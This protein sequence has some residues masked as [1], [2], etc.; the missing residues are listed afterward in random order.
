MNAEL[1]RLPHGLNCHNADIDHMSVLII[2]PLNYIDHQMSAAIKE[3][4]CSLRLCDSATTAF[5]LADK[6][7]PDL[8]V[9]DA[10]LPDMELSLFIRRFKRLYPDCLLLSM[11]NAS[12]SCDAAEAMKAGAIDYLRKPFNAAQ[13]CNCLGHA[14][15]ANRPFE[16]LIVASH[17][18]RQVLQLARRAAQTQASILITGESGTGKECLAQFIHQN[19]PRAAQP[20][21]AINCAAIPE[22]MLEAVLFGYSKGAFTGA[23]NAQSGKFE[24]ANGGTILLDEIAELP[25][26]LQAKI[27]RVLQEREVE[28]L[29]SHQKVML[30]I[31]VIAA[32]NR[33]LREMV[34]QGLFREDLFYRLDVLPLSWPAL[35]ERQEDIL[36]LAEHF[37]DKYASHPGYQLSPDARQILISYNWPGNVRELE[38]VIQRALILTKGLHLQPSD[39][40]LPSDLMPL[41][42]SVLERSEMNYQ[43]DGLAG[44]KR[45][46][47]FQYVLDVL[48]RFDGHRAQT[49][50]ALGLTT[51]A[52]RYKLAAMRDHGIDIDRFVRV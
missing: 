5:V 46:A 32:T 39:L 8:I 16:N 22:S 14:Q 24:Q 33:D 49:A 36:P 28:R 3:F 45:H 44:S 18:S 13:L 40:M 1:V 9:V 29:G 43:D 25:L 26:Q 2:D 30:D 34:R 6:Y 37:I 51:R 38:N 11:V 19:S 12:Q 42:E 17:A 20:F 47:E 27:L 35:R 41:T 23:S 52:L 4:G 21:V 7:K 10:S 48:R 31:R 15:R 50:E